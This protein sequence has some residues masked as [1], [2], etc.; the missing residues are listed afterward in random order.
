[1][2]RTCALLALLMLSWLS[3]GQAAARTWTDK[4]G[5]EIEAELV[6]VKSGMAVLKLEN[7]KTIKKAIA[8]LSAEDQEFIKESADAPDPTPAPKK[9]ATK[10]PTSKKPAPVEPETMEPD[11]AG[12]TEPPKTGPLKT[13]ASK[14]AKATSGGVTVEVVGVSINKPLPADPAAEPGAFMLMAGL[15]QSGTKIV[16]SLADPQ[17]EIVTLDH[18]K[19]KITACTDSSGGNLNKDDGSRSSGFSPFPLQ[20]QPGRH[21]GV[22]EVSQ[23]LT[24]A[25]G[26]TKI[27]LQ[28]EVVLQ[29]G[30]GEKTAEQADVPL[31]AAGQISAG[32]V[33]F[34][35]AP[36]DKQAGFSFASP[37]KLEGAGAQQAAEPKIVLTLT[38]NKPIDMIKKIVFLNAAGKEIAQSDLGSGTTGFAGNMT[39]ERTIGL[40]ED[41]DKATVRIVSFEKLDSITVPIDF[42]IGV[43][44]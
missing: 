40:A 10:K 25:P 37:F 16:L 31:K 17:R 4:K 21:F 3:V 14:G 35:T 13:T 33:P 27:R 32:P 1:M 15:G 39:Y 7:G 6:E 34:K 22:V 36:G 23:S 29:C 24:P 11:T 41:L 5:K 28:G 42:E 12:P 44:F 18:E 2:R 38:T 20:L 9:P 19:S 26:A 43:G 30:V 8:T